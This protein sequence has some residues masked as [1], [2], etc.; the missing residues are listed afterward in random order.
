MSEQTPQ[1]ESTQN[2]KDDAPGA[3]KEQQQSG[4]A[5]VDSPEQEGEERFDAG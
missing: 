4:E 1:D 5:P 3:S 2:L